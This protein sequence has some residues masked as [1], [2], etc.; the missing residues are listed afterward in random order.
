[1][2]SS[3][4]PMLYVINFLSLFITYWLDKILCMISPQI[5]LLVLKYYKKPP[6]YDIN[7]TLKSL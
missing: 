3:G 7:L 2:Y 5:T 1:M 4:I 6:Q